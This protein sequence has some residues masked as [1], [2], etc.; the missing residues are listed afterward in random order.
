MPHRSRTFYSVVRG[1]TYVTTPPSPARKLFERLVSPG[2]G[3]SDRES[4]HEP[5]TRDHGHM[6]TPLSPM[7]DRRPEG[8]PGEMHAPRSP[9]EPAAWTQRGPGHPLPLAAPR[10]YEPPVSALG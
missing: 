7:T 10:P 4:N 3:W 2:P 9:A 5:R 1:W 8:D 6:S